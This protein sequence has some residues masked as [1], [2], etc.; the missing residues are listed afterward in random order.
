MAAAVTAAGITPRSCSAPLGE[1][2]R[3]DQTV[4]E[5]EDH[6]LDLGGHPAAVEAL[7]GT[8]HDIHPAVELEVITGGDVVGHRDLTPRVAGAA[9]EEHPPVRLVDGLPIDRVH[10]VIA[11]HRA[12]DE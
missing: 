1:V 12:R 6:R 9:A 3:V 4:A 10:E 5:R 7:D 8:S 2:R 11:T